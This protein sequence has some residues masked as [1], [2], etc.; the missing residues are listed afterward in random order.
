M[1][2]R[3]LH[4]RR[5]LRPSRRIA[6]LVSAGGGDDEG[7]KGGSS[8]GSG[9]S[10]GSGKGDGGSGSS[11]SPGGKPQKSGIFQGWEDRVAY[12]PEFPFKVL[13][14]QVIGVSACVVGDMSARPNW[15]E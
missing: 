13:M 11:G 12:D 1:S 2:G 3:T 7:G 14:E 5:A 6:A 9:G 10:G 8:G 4:F 15:G